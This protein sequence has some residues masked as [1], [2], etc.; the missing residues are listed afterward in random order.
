MFIPNPK[1]VSHSTVAHKRTRLDS[2]KLCTI[3]LCRPPNFSTCR[4]RVRL[5]PSTRIPTLHLS[6]HM[7]R[8]R[9]TSQKAMGCYSVN[10][11]YIL[12]RNARA[13]P[14]PTTSLGGSILPVRKNV[15]SKKNITTDVMI[16]LLTC[17]IMWSM[18]QIMYF[19][20][21]RRSAQYPCQSHGGGLK[22]AEPQEQEHFATLFQHGVEQING[23]HDST[24]DLILNGQAFFNVYKEEKPKLDK[25]LYS[26]FRDRML[27]PMDV[28]EFSEDSSSRKR[29]PP[30]SRL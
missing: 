14:T 21:Q 22:G 15:N 10:K 28:D 5:F 16:T 4:L 29:S 17:K 23:M 20:H 27:W 25:V 30:E 18:Y 24:Q 6:V 11:G 7:M 26:L 9:G 3:K 1:A 8:A 19:P 13:A 2:L 12:K